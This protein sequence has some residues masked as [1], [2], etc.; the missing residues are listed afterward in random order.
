MKTLSLLLKETDKRFEKKFGKS[1]E[2][3][4][5]FSD[6]SKEEVKC[7]LNQEIKRI[8]KEMEKEIVPK[9]D[10]KCIRDGKHSFTK[11]PSA[12]CIKCHAD[13]FGI[14]RWNDA[15]NFIKDKIT[16]FTSEEG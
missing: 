4:V 1:R 6:E 7:F 16:H 5:F 10:K 9:E 15:I 8:I 11:Y 14:Q 13:R 12:Y 3:T 2:G